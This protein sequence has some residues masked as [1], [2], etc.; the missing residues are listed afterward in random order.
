MKNDTN[1]L[2]R[3]LLAGGA[4]TL[5]AAGLGGLSR[6]A[7]GQATTVDLPSSTASATW[8]LFPR[9]GRSSCSPRG[10]RSSRRRSQSSTMA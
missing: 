4:G 6:V 7:L 2:R 10:R 3:R 8:S 1:R 9:S 5:A